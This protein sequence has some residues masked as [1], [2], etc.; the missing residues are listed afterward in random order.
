[1]L[2]G[3]SNAVS[4]LI[5]SSVAPDVHIYTRSKLGWVALPASVPAFATYYNTQ[6][7]WPEASLDRLQ[8][9]KAPKR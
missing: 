2:L 9:L 5:P 4:P 8:A 7:L 6:K 1:M 3:T